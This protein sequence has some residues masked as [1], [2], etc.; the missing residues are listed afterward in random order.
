MDLVRSFIKGEEG[1][2]TVE[3]AI[4]T[5]I[6]VVGVIAV[7]GLI[8]PG[9]STPSIRFRKR[10]R[11]SIRE[12][13]SRGHLTMWASTLFAHPVPAIQ[14]G[15][16][17]GASL[18]AAISDARSRRIS[19]RLTFPLLAAGLASAAAFGGAAG[20][21]DSALAC[22]LLALPYV[23]LFVFAGGGA[24]DAKL[25]GAIG[26]WLGLINGTVVLFA[27]ALS[28]TALAL[29]HAIAARRSRVVLG[30]VGMAARGMVGPCW[31]AC[32]RKTPRPCCPPSR[33]VRR[34]PTASP[35]WPAWPLLLE[36]SSLGK[37]HEDTRRAAGSRWSR[38]P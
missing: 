11:D 10:F 7:L 25:M 17:I 29:A 36:E 18:V 30:S 32:P 24:G 23:V 8:G 22:A 34:S 20:V 14:W 37:S 19:N 9:S 13:G 6:I 38:R 3:Y 33:A 31:G 4:I 27:V 16:V 21:L 12:G 15:V 2:E 28:G 5:G 26:S 1:L 35:S